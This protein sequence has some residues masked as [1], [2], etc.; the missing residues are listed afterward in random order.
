MCAH[1]FGVFL[2]GWVQIS[3]FFKCEIH[4]ALELP[5]N[6]SVY[7]EQIHVFNTAV[8]AE[9]TVISPSARRGALM[10]QGKDTQNS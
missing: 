1:T 7:L 10:L 6:I 5:P 3:E 2:C 9:L 4:I 8:T